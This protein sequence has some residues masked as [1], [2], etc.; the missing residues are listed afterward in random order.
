MGER[1]GQNK[2]YPPDYDPRA[3]GLNKFL[4]T[5][6][7]RERARKIH[8]GIIIIR[9]EMP[10]N[11]W[12]EGCKNHIGMGV[13]YN[14]EKTK[15]GMY[16]ST[17][18]YQ[19][20][21]KCHLCENYIVIKTDPGNLDY[22]IVSGARRQEG[23]WDPTENGQVVPDTKET[24][25]RLFDDPMYKLEHQ[26]SD[27]K[28]SDDAKPAIFKLYERNHYVWDDDYTANSRLRAEFR[29]KKKELKSEADKD[30]ALLLKSSL[31][32]ELL[33]ENDQD[34]RLAAMMKLHSERVINEKDRK[35][36]VINKPALPAIKA[37]SSLRSQRLLNSK[38]S[39]NDLGIKR[40][41]SDSCESLAKIIKPTETITSNDT[42]EKL[43]ESSSH[44]NEATQEKESTKTT[45][46]NHMDD[47]S[48]DNGSTKVSS[49]LSL[50]CNYSSN[51]SSDD[52]E[53]T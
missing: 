4:G 38:L 6:A 3:G 40:K 39:K 11:I 16:F 23:R 35:N 49:S 45:K 41:T 20:K 22:E 25:R 29:N 12:C 2:Y 17:P 26:A 52:E 1:K 51:S 8:L 10:Y 27:L 19:F 34:A 37:I 14:A 46:R 44:S 9:F 28:K 30:K 18:V 42:P 43:G 15:V 33:P 7:L 31:D 36:E 32:I 24:Q 13:R 21:M 53:A 48:T 5:H 50:V 47:K